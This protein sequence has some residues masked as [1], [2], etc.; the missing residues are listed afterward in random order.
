LAW[1][2]R[3]KIARVEISTD[4]GSTWKDAD[5]QSPVLSKAAT[6]FRFEW[7]WDG[8]PAAIASRS[9]DETG[10]VQPSLDELVRVRGR[11]S[12]YHCNAIKMWF[13]HQDGAVS[14]A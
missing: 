8:K 6:R 2:G 4:G 3:G 13:V 14:H 5:L 9:T 11:F 12:F 7:N 10:Y 1:S